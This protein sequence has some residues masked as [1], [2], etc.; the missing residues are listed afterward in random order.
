MRRDY[1]LCLPFYGGTP[2]A[3]PADLMNADRPDPADEFMDPALQVDFGLGPLGPEPEGLIKIAKPP[4]L[5]GTPFQEVTLN[6]WSYKIAPTHPF[7]GIRRHAR[8]VSDDKLEIQEVVPFFRKNWSIYAYEPE[9]G[10]DTFDEGWPEVPADPDGGRPDVTP[11]RLP[12]AITWACD[13]RNA[14]IFSRTTLRIPEDDF[15][16]PPP[17]I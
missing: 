1:L 15:D 5:Q 11:A 8:R 13:N 9:G 10:T 14:R 4:E 3:D 12:E 16:V 17:I 6:G 7:G 2:P